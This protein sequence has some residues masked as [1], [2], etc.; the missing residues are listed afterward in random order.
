[1][2]NLVLVSLLGSIFCAT[3]NYTV[4]AAEVAIPA[5]KDNTLYEDISGGTS[6]GAGSY[7]FVGRVGAGGGGAIR[8]GLIA[9]DIAGAVPAGSIIT[10][11]SLRLS[12]SRTVSGASQVTLHRTTADWG[13]GASDAS[14][15]EGSGAPAAEN[16]ATWTKR[17]FGTDLDW[18]TAGGD[19]DPV[20]SAFVSVGDVGAYN[21][22]SAGMLDDVQAW[23][24]T[25]ASNF[26]WI[27]RGDEATVGSAKRFDT[28]ENMI[29]QNRPV[30]TVT[31]TAPS[32]VHDWQLFQ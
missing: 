16:D 27:V 24:S 22:S 7:F 10:A 32:S 11:A 3:F 31:Y 19:Y 15:Q 5:A 30:L 13:E 23:F 28:R 2:R 8:R 26:G 20:A 25:P 21:W 29:T 17:F 18:A 9:F 6:N 14:A 12:M 1:M 4:C